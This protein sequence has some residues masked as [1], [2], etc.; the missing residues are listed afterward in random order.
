MT[1]PAAWLAAR[2]GWARA[3]LALGL[4]A[5]GALA[6]P[7]WH[8]LPAVVIAFTGLAWLID[9]ART[10]P[11]ALLA[12]WLFGF[13]GFGAGL[14]WLGNAFLVDAERFGAFALP[15]VLGL[16]AGLA[17]FPAAAAWLAR[18]ARPGIG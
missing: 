18:L 1:R 17:L 15:A 11:Q 13:G 8:L 12:G 16:A 6:L 9:A 10:R 2:S 14:A 7:P 3:A 5:E 4:G